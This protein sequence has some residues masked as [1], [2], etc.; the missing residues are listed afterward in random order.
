VQQQKPDSA[1]AAHVRFDDIQ[2]RG[3]RDN[4]IDGIAFR[5]Q[6]N[7]IGRLL[8]R[9]KELTAAIENGLADA[10]TKVGVTGKP[11]P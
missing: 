5:T 2:R 9:E 11:A 6:Q 8:D 7:R 10:R 1:N 3:H 4:R